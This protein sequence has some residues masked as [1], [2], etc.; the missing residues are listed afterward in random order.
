MKFGCSA[1]LATFIFTADQQEKYVIPDSITRAFNLGEQLHAKQCVEAA[2]I[3][4]GVITEVEHRIENGFLQGYAIISAKDETYKVQFQ[5]EYLFVF[6]GQQI[7]VESPN[8]ISL[9]EARSKIPISSESLRYGLQV[10]LVSL[11]PPDFWLTPRALAQVN[12]AAF[13]LQS[14]LEE[15]IYD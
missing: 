10:E 3:I 8:I 14:N 9:L 15:K 13:G 7:I 11:M 12:R 2:T 1:A 5:N 4:T 6:K